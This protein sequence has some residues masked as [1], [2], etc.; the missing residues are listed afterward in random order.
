M[1]SV[2]FEEISR[3]NGMDHTVQIRTSS[4]G[5]GGT[6]YKAAS[7]GVWVRV[8]RLFVARFGYELVKV[9]LFE[10]LEPKKREINER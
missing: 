7:G 1:E 5:T 4:R 6:G 2:K 3:S 9:E 8:N 10:V